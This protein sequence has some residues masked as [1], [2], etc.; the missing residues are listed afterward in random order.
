MLLSYYSWLIFFIIS[1]FCFSI[2]MITP[3]CHLGLVLTLYLQNVLKEL[4]LIFLTFSYDFM[5]FWYEMKLTFYSLPIMMIFQGQSCSVMKIHVSVKIAGN[6]N[7]VHQVRLKLQATENYRMCTQIQE[8]FLVIPLIYTKKT[9]FICAA[10]RP[11]IS[12]WHSY[13]CIPRYAD[14][15][16]QFLLNNL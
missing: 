16:L 7:T 12:T 2:S 8:S 11:Q 9:C 6:R 1:S 15:I 4:G 10:Q 14:E 3:K 13:V 5:R